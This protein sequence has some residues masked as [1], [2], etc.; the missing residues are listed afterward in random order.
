[1]SI[2]DQGIALRIVELLLGYFVAA[3]GPIVVRIRKGFSI[4]YEPEKELVLGCIV[5][6]GYN[7][8]DAQSVN[9]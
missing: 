7:T 6:Y 1:M 9:A 2:L 3:A 4:C 8:V 5:Y